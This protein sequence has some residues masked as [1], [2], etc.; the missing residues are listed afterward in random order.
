MIV[1]ACRTRDDKTF[2]AT[3][4]PQSVR[5][6]GQ[7]HCDLRHIAKLKIVI[8]F[9]SVISYIRMSHEKPLNKIILILKVT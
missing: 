5:A 4:A 8:S 7:A 2:G 3:S 1:Q 6:N 9:I